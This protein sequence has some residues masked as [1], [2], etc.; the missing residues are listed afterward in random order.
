MYQLFYYDEL[1]NM[2]ILLSFGSLRDALAYGRR[3]RRSQPGLADSD[4]YVQYAHG[5]GSQLLGNLAEV[6]IRQRIEA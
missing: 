5:G 6:A 3:W 1:G 2:I 4:V